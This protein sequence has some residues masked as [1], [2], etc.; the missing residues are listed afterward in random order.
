MIHCQHNKN[1]DRWGRPH[2]HNNHNWD[3]GNLQ[4]KAFRYRDSE[5]GMVP[6]RAAK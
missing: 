6:A 3:L 2:C 1:Q 5:L 4:G